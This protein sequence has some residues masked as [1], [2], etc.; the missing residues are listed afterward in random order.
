MFEDFPCTASSHSIFH[1]MF[2]LCKESLNVAQVLRQVSSVSFAF[3]AS[4]YSSFAAASS[5]VSHNS[6]SHPR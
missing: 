3:V 4:S 6:E 5:S 2:Q 1:V